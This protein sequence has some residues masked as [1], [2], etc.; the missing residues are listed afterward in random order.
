MEDIYFYILYING[1]DYGGYSILGEGGGFSLYFQNVPFRFQSLLR[2]LLQEAAVEPC[3][4]LDR[5]EYLE[6]D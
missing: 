1:V 3:E 4:S 2:Y 6:W 5:E